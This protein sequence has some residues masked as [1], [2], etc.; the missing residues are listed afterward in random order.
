MPDKALVLGIN[1]YLS[2]GSLRGCVNDVETMKSLL[3]DVFRFP[4]KNVRSFT[5]DQV[6]KGRV[7]EQLQ[8][9]FQ[10]AKAGDRVVLHFSGHGSYVDDK[11]GDEADGRDE[12]IALYD[13]DFNDPET[14]LLDDELREWTLKKPRGV[15]LTVIL[16]NCNSGSGTRMMLA[17]DPRGKGK[18]ILI[19]K[20]ATLSRSMAEMHGARGLD[21]AVVAADALDPE[22]P[23][24]VIARC[25]EPPQSVKNRVV[26]ASARA[27]TAA[28]YVNVQDLNHVLITACRADQ[29]AADAVIDGR[30]CGAFTHYLDQT[31]RAYGARIRREDLINQVSSALQQAHFSQVP[32]LEGATSHGSLFATAE[33]ARSDLAEPTSWAF[34]HLPASPLPATAIDHSSFLAILDKLAPL[35]PETRKRVLDLYERQFPRSTTAG[36]LAATARGAGQRVLVCVH[37]I[38]KHPPGY[39]DPWWEAL[40]PFTNEF[41]AGTLT[42]TRQEVQW[43]DLTNERALRATSVTGEQSDLRDEIV[44]SLED[45]VDRHAME[46]GLPPRDDDSGPRALGDTRGFVSI[47]YL[48]CIDDFVTYMTVG[49]MREAILARFTDVVRPLLQRGA[50]L[51]IISHSWGTV[52]A[53]EGLRE[54]AEKDGLTTPHV[55]NLFSVGA[56]LSIS[57][58]KRSLRPSNRDGQRPA[59]VRRWV[60]LNAVG[61]PIGGPLRGRPYAVDFD[62]P[63]L[64]PFGCSRILRLT[65]PSCAHGS[66]FKTGNLAANRDVF[67]R[68]INEP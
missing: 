66:Y 33:E 32:Q 18:Q 43:S 59:M 30:P 53:Y 54:L 67:A 35:D 31:V 37:G 8:W 22:N 3:I 36:R 24:S 19:D 12:L 68:F 60:N 28:N 38:C 44:A 51:D 49:R 5:N 61:D 29:T 7:L 41:G 25:I 17:P 16:D 62:F 6:V 26:K 39:S 58:V 1:D 21:A 52:V 23:L 15:E 64:E 27:T 46:S 65:N 11:N 10:G 13:M 20:N 50:E 48:N 34:D 40:R 42:Q 55:R 9:L 45:R 2:V 57:A 4:E 14:Y 47:P 56:A 63:S